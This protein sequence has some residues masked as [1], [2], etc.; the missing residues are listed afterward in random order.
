MSI[1][2]SIRYGEGAG[3]SLSSGH[4]SVLSRELLLVV[5]KKDDNNCSQC[6]K[7]CRGKLLDFVI[8]SKI[9]YCSPN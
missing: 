4:G 2:R 6:L 3:S 5:T 7:K 9:K 8:N 1:E